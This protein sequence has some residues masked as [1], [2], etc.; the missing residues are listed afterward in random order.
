MTITVE[1]GTGKVDAVSYISAADA[2][3]YFS[4]RGVET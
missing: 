3:T 2:A 1:D 4:L